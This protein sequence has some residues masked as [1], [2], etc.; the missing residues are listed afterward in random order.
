MIPHTPSELINVGKGNKEVEEIR[1][2]VVPLL[3]FALL[4]DDKTVEVMSGAVVR[5]LVADLESLVDGLKD[6]VEVFVVGNV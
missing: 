5:V 3:G 4:G 2:I 6:R 1:D